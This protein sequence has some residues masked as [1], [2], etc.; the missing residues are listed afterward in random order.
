MKQ[1]NFWRVSVPCVC[2]CAVR[3]LC[4]VVQLPHH[5]AVVP[6]IDMTLSKRR[7]HVS[8][9]FFLLNFFP[10][11]FGFDVSDVLS[12]SVDEKKMTSETSCRHERVNTRES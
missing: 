8:L 3:A 6:L 4:A 1:K 7:C 12:D 9:C 11:H 10:K 5:G 2:T